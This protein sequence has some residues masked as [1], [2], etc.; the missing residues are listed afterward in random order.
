MDSLWSNDGNVTVF[1]ITT[2]A[3]TGLIAAG[4]PTVAESLLILITFKVLRLRGINVSPVLK[5]TSLI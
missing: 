5:V 2:C 4:T 3:I 1:P